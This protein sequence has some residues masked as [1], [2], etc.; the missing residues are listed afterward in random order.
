MIDPVHFSYSRMFSCVRVFK[1]DCK[2]NKNN[3]K[4]CSLGPQKT[5]KLCKSK[6]LGGG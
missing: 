5:V 3:S 6:N 2:G 4:I 1:S